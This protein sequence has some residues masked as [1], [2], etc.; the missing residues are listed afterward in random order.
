MK[1]T[2]I[3][4]ALFMTAFLLSGCFLKSVHPL[5]KEEDSIVVPGLEGRWESS[6][7][8]WT[9]A[10]SREY[11]P[12]SIS[13]DDEDLFF[14]ING[15]DSTDI[16]GMKGYLMIHEDIG[17]SSVDSTF[18]MTYFVNL[19]DNLFLDLYPLDLRESSLYT[20]HFIPIHTFAKVEL[21]SDSLD[22]RLF[23]DS[24]IEDQIKD[25]RVRIKHE[26]VEDGVLITAS[27]EELQKFI[28]KYGNIEDAYEGS[29]SLKRAK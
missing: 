19:G 24:W 22:I 1:R 27:T 25:N 18:F 16:E 20:N 10:R 11:F 8:R 28:I 4:T 9:F 29:T 26:K 13:S 23:K 17:G 3:F 14:N 21:K 15:E 12:S 7:E 6:E 5:V 2:V